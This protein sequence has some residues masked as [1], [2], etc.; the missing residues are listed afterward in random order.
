MYSNKVSTS[1]TT[2]TCPQTTY[3]KF[4]IL[5]LTKLTDIDGKKVHKG[6]LNLC[7]HEILLH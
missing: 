7:E 3:L 6:T 4:S 1:L 5:R 2:A